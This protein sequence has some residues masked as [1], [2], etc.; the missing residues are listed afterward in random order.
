[1]PNGEPLSDYERWRAR[2]G[3]GQVTV[4]PQPTV[5]P[6]PPD[7]P[8]VADYDRW[9][10]SWQ[11]PTLETQY[12]IPEQEPEEGLYERA[13][14]EFAFNKNIDTSIWKTIRDQQPERAKEIYASVEKK[15]RNENMI[16]QTI[17]RLASAVPVFGP[18]LAEKVFELSE[19]NFT[20]TELEALKDPLS[21]VYDPTMKGIPIGFDQSIN[22]RDASELTTTLAR[23]VGIGTGTTYTLLKLPFF[24]NG[25]YMHLMTH[26]NTMKRVGSRAAKAALDFNID[27][28]SNLYPE[29]TK[30]GIPLEEKIHSMV[31]TFPKSTLSGS[32]FGALG[33]AKGVIKQYGGVFAAGYGS[34]L[35]E[36]AGH[37]EAFKGGA[38]LTAMHFT[39]ALGT[40]A[41]KLAFKN[42]GKE[43]HIPDEDV[44]FYADMIVEE[45]YDKTKPEW[46]V[47]NPGKY[48][49]GAGRTGTGEV[50]VVK[51]VGKGKKRFVVVEDR[52]SETGK[53]VKINAN[54]FYKN[55]SRRRNLAD[56]EKVRTHRLNKIHERM[57]KM[58]I[59][60]TEKEQQI[61]R[62]EM[63]ARE[64]PMQEKKEGEIPYYEYLSRQSISDLFKT[65]ERYGI[66]R[67]AMKDMSKA[68]MVEH[69][70]KKVPRQPGRRLSLADASPEQLHNI[71]RRLQKMET[72]SNV[73][74]DIRQGVYRLPTTK[75]VGVKIKTDNERILFSVQDTVLTKFR[76]D[77]SASNEA[78]QEGTRITGE[79]KRLGI[80]P[81]RHFEIWRAKA[82]E[83]DALDSLSAKELEMMDIL[84]ESFE[85][86]RLF[87]ERT[88]ILDNAIDHYWPGIFK[89]E[90]KDIKTKIDKHLQVN[91]KSQFAK[92]KKFRTPTEAEAFAK[93]AGLEVIYDI[94]YLVEKW[95]TSMGKAAS[96]KNFIQR[97]KD[98]PNSTTGD[99]LI[100]E[101]KIEGYQ[102]ITDPYFV[103]AVTGKK[104][105]GTV[106]VHPLVAGEFLSIYRPWAPS[107]EL[108]A[109]LYN[110]YWKWAG[111]V[112]R[113]IMYNPLIH[114]WNIYSD[115]FD[116]LWFSSWSN[117]FP[118][119]KTARLTGLFPG[120]KYSPEKQLKMYKKLGF[121]G[122]LA[123][124][125]R[126][127]AGGGVNQEI[128][129]RRGVEID[130]YMQENMPDLAANPMTNLAKHPLKTLKQLSDKVLWGRIVQGAQETVFALKYTHM[131]N[132]GFTPERAAAMAGH[133][134]NDLLGTIGKEVFTPAEGAFLNALFFARNWTISNMRLVTGA[135]GVQSPHAQFLAHKGL[136]KAEMQALQGEY[137]KHLIKGVLGLTLFAN[138]MNKMATGTS[139]FQESYDPEKATWAMQNDPG[140]RLDVNLGVRDKKGRQVYVVMPLFR[141]MRDYFSWFGDP[142][143]TFYNKMSPLWKQTLEQGFDYSLWSRRR[144]TARGADWKANAKRRLTHFIEG[145]S[146]ASQIPWYQRPGEVKDIYE[147][148]APLVGTW[149]RHGPAGGR[150]GELINE[151]LA[152]MK[153]KRDEID[154]IIDEMIMTG[155]QSGAIADMLGTG[156]YKTIDGML[157][158]LRKF[159]DPLQYKW[160]VMLS[161]EMQ[162]GF[163]EWV[164][165]E[166]GEDYAQV[167]LDLDRVR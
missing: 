110:Q 66:D 30:E 165:E 1:M 140:H 11:R 27:A 129:G 15:T 64:E 120:I 103:R 128:T 149:V 136:T 50:Q 65:G 26:T 71:H 116:E 43:Q 151:Y 6:T 167:Q 150:A 134:T 107:R 147:Q 83:K 86:G 20:P 45:K 148:L 78:Y 93:E 159:D 25:K 51:E 130:E 160:D 80:T 31:M 101:S 40:R 85:S 63:G 161:R 119:V 145:I 121:D 96:S 126:V 142:L 32:L 137:A 87:G 22:L 17:A 55:F 94:P 125:Q 97:I 84:E 38:L 131:L 133:Y 79:L 2:F 18:N 77:Q 74:R 21:P 48:G 156:R 76:N 49:L 7:T 157:D 37:K 60:N 70:N 34:A 68:E 73:E 75:E 95:W 92:E 10:R 28:Y 154:I 115:T 19:V 61:K 58:G 132:K 99:S 141:Y 9:R 24:K 112:K 54:T 122:T 42:W 162:V 138:A 135:L 143:T 166:H 104:Y 152:E 124:L 46:F 62:E 72:K 102:G 3:T 81:D 127:M 4:S 108:P 113:V 163:E 139:G 144:I 146:P 88:G 158:R 39:N 23:F 53:P 123:D 111:R 8:Y 69:I 106:W 16:R 57:S 164:R 33:G 118:L 44:S 56:S 12:D 153:F 109:K 52:H 114:G 14:G 98:L 90:P 41:G 59:T 89:G 100:S 67:S 105:A 36:G 35:V 13:V 29:L 155:D 82:G 5:D 47:P 91:P 117:M